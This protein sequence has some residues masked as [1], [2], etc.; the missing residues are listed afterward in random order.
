MT[1]TAG[2]TV[3]GGARGGLEDDTNDYGDEV[4]EEDSH[5]ATMNQQDLSSD[6]DALSSS[7]EVSDSESEEEEEKVIDKDEGEE[8]STILLI[9]TFT[10]TKCRCRCSPKLSEFRLVARIGGDKY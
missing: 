9:E 4:F 8:G 7:S 1:Q 3:S 5:F 6:N 2:M 10:G